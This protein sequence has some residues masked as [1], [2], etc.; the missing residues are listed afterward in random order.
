MSQSLSIGEFADPVLAAA[1]QFWPQAYGLFQPGIND[2]GLQTWS[3]NRAL[4]VEVLPLTIDDAGEIRP[5]RHNYFELVVGCSGTTVFEIGRSEH[6]AVTPGDLLVIGSS[7]YHRPLRTRGVPSKLA[8]LIF[9]SEALGSG[10][11]SLEQ[12]YYLSSLAAQGDDFNRLVP[13]KAGI[14]YKV[15]QLMWEIKSELGTGHPIADLHIRTCLK[16]ILSLLAKHYF[17]M[18]PSEAI[19]H[20][21][22]DLLRLRPLLDYVDRHYNEPLS[23]DGAA[24]IVYMSRSCFTRLFK[25][26]MGRTFAHYLT[27]IRIQQ[28]QSLLAIT[29]Q[30]I[31]EVGWNVGFSDQSHFSGVFRRTVNMTPLQ[32]RQEAR[33]TLLEKSGDGRQLT[34]PRH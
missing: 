7:T 25:Q 31:A 30:Q 24:S 33:R 34:C 9:E 20:R 22:E 12:A 2:N 8:V 32:Y 17:S 3:F 29:E 1:S 23:L 21:Q 18:S 11:S 26:V 14:P 16:M 13:A 4:P 6:L 15:L 19:Y 5:N 10:G 28:A 27:Q